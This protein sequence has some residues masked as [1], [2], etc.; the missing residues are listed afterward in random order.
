MKQPNL[1]D[2]KRD[3]IGTEKIRASLAKAKNIKITINIDT[4]SLFA[5]REIARDTGIPY[6]RLF[7]VLLEKSLTKR[8][9]TESRLDRLE[10]ELK[11]MKR[12]AAA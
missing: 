9:S 3:E 6:Q 10:Q 2:L 5:L 12:Q 7:N 11:K 4:K 8:E 1:K